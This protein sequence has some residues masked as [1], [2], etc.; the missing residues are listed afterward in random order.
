MSRLDNY[1]EWYLDI[2]EKAA[3]SDKRYP[4]KGMNV[5]TP[6]GWKI[7]SFID[8]YIR[9]EL[10]ATGHDEVSFPLL[11]P[12]TEFKKEKDHIKVVNKNY[13]SNNSSNQTSNRNLHIV[14][15]STPESGSNFSFIA[16]DYTKDIFEKDIVVLILPSAS[17]P[18]DST[19][20]TPNIQIGNTTYVLGEKKNA[21]FS[22]GYENLS[23]G[24]FTII[25]ILD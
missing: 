13:L 20:L 8:R 18:Y 16:P 7:M 23:T 2:V 3:L 11:I 12:E 15:L 19:T 1:N 22:Q 10:D 25:T 4:I 6:Y 21:F 17:N 24:L 5:W 14:S 9:R